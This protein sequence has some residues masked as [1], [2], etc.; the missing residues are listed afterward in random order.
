M[1]LIPFLKA[2]RG[3]NTKVSDARLPY[4]PETG[5]QFLA[6]AVN[7]DIDASGRISRRKGVRKVANRPDPHSLWSNYA[8]TVCFFISE[9]K[10]HR[11]RE[12]G[13]IADIKIPVEVRAEANYCEIGN[14]VYFCN[15]YE[16]GIIRECFT[17]ED[18]V[19]TDYVGPETTRNFSGPPMGGKMGFHAGRL[20]IA[21]DSHLFYS[22]PFNYGCYDLSRS[23]ISLSGSEITAIV[24]LDRSLF[25]S[26]NDAIYWLMGG[27][28]EEWEL[29][30]LLISPM[31]PGTAAWL[32]GEL[33]NENVQG[34]CVIF[35]TTDHGICLFTEQGKVFFLTEDNIELPSS[36]KGYAV[37]NKNNNFQ[38]LT[39]LEV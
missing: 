4:D 10:L 15:G 9:H 14:D 31:V 29:R 1:K 32:P 28:P 37:F 7:V 17:W 38:Y 6:E 16:Q 13:L 33:V 18:W 25:I 26:T 5:V 11:L 8:Q 22:E 24:T 2:A 35:T 36:G 39:F 21:V 12:D 34:S 19:Q 20:F 3:L 30:R 27:T 23:F